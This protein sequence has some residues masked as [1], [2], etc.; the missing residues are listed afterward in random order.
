[1]GKPYYRIGQAAKLLGISSYHLRRLCELGIIEAE[2]SGHQWQ[3]LVSVIEEVQRTGVP[4]IPSGELVSKES[5]GSSGSNSRL[6]A[7]PSASIT[8]SAEEA[9]ASEIRGDQSPE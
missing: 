6:L 9:A 2:F 8:N 5:N 3:I 1:M 4:P 7:A